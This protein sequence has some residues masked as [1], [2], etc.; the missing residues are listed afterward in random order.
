MTSGITSIA[1]IRVPSSDPVFLSMVAIHVVLGLCCVV[2]GA[3]A[4]LSVKGAGRHPKAGIVY[5][6]SLA[7]LFASAAVLSMMRWSEDYHLFI[8]GALAFGTGYIGRL[9]R[10]RRSVRS[11]RLHIAMMGCSYIVLLTAFYVD[12]GRQLPLWREL[13]DWTF[14]VLPALAGAPLMFWALLRHPRLTVEA[15]PR[16]AA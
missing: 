16:A 1:G 5:Y 13:P 8:L 3:F 10:R 6:W 15:H 7:A 11:L 4:M 9:A 14:W 12:N 2:S